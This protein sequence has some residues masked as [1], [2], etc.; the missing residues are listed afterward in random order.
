MNKA[1][2]KSLQQI[3]NRIE[4]IKADFEGILEEENECFDNIP[5]NLQGSERYETAEEILSYL[6][7]ANDYFDE[8]IE[9]ITN[10]IE[11]Y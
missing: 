5:E 8:V 4:E 10:A 2:R 6:D 11:E 1:R 9:N 7:D 3:I